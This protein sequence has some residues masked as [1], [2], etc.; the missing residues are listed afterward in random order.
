M[1]PEPIHPAL[2][3]FPIVFA[4]LLP[5][6]AIAAI[7]AVRRGASARSAWWVPLLLAAA[8][9]GS[10]WLAVRTGEAQ[11]EAVERVVAEAPLHDH[12]E[13][14]E[15]F[16]W[17]SGLAV[18]VFAAGLARGRLGQAGRLAAAAAAVALSVAGY[19]VGASGGEL[20]YEHGAAQA[21]LAS[22]PSSGSLDPMDRHDEDEED[23][24]HE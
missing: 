14:G 18:L 22:A 23:D 21:Y 15:A 4:V 8:L 16:L 13:A 10:A 20:V 17:L 7:V 5:V 6:A 19:R 1:L 9:F 3:H 11:E 2:V 12:E 24:E